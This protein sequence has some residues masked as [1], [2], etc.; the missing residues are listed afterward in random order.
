MKVFIGCLC[1]RHSAGKGRGSHNGSTAVVPPL[2]GSS[3]TQWGL[4]AS[5]VC[6]HTY[7]AGDPH[8]C[9]VFEGSTGEEAGETGNGFSTD[10]LTCF[11]GK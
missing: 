10:S 3:L 9:L 11:L 6:S 5:P 7:L 4:R 2:I 8:P 1:A